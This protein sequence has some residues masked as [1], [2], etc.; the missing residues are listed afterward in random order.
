M[1]DSDAAIFAP[2]LIRSCCINPLKN[3]KIK[4]ISSF[5]MLPGP[6]HA[7]Y[8]RWIRSWVIGCRSELMN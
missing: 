5:P 8:F 3:N 1:A 6:F 4:E 2:F 7:L